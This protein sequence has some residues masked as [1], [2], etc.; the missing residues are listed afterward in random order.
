[1]LSARWPVISVQDVLTGRPVVGARLGAGFR[2]GSPSTGPDGITYCSRRVSPNEPIYADGGG[3]RFGRCHVTRIT[4]DSFYATAVLERII[5]RTVLGSVVNGQSGRRLRDVS[6]RVGD[7]K[8][9]TDSQGRFVLRG[10]CN[11]RSDIKAAHPKLPYQQCSITV[12]EGDTVIAH[13]SMYG[14]SATGILFGTVTDTA[15]GRPVAGATISIHETEFTIGTD[16]NGDY[17]FRRVPPGEYLVEVGHPSYFAK[18]IHAVT[19]T[20]TPPVRVDWAVHRR[21]GR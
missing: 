4:S 18:R 13:I 7:G 6:V 8:A 3:Y 21:P 17:E 11:S 16:R 10:V 15:T 9:C 2:L 1:R 12:G 20:P 14:S 5:D 19:L